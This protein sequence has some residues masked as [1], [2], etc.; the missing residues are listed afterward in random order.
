[1]VKI[2]L[3]CYLFRFRLRGVKHIIFYQ[4][5]QYGHFYSEICN[6]LLDL[7]HKESKSD[8]TCT[9]MY[10]KYDAQRLAAVVSTERAGL[11]INSDKDIHMLVTGDT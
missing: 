5:P 1:M 2:K 10:T 9:V 3:D 7:K 11:M 6:M 8:F 4:L